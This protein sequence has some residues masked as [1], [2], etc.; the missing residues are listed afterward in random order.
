MDHYPNP[1]H[2]MLKVRG[3]IDTLLTLAGSVQMTYAAFCEQM[4][5]KVSYYNAWLRARDVL[6]QYN[7]IRFSLNDQNEK[8]IG[9]TDTGMAIAQHLH[10]IRQLLNIPEAVK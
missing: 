6:R 9:L 2:A 1:L 4:N 7:C 10:Q 8:L 3:V 5:A